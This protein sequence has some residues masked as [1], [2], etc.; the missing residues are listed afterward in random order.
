MGHYRKERYHSL[1]PMYYH[2]VAVAITT[3]DITNLDSFIEAKNLVLELKKQ[4]NPNF[5]MALTGNHV[6]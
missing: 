6:K 5:V 1:A 4:G 3:Y 2:G